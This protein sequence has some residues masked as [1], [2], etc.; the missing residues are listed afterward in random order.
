M[1]IRKTSHITHKDQNPRNSK[2]RPDK[3][4]LLRKRK[5]QPQPSS[6]GKSGGLLGWPFGHRL[7]FVV[8]LVLLG[9]LLWKQMN[10][11]TAN[12]Y[13]IN[14]T[15]FNTLVA[16]QKIKK[17]RI[18]NTTLYGE[19]TESLK[20]GETSD[21]REYRGIIVIIGEH[22][23]DFQDKLVAQGIEVTIDPER[24]WMNIFISSLPWILIFGI[25][26]F[27]IRQMQGGP[28]GVFSFGKSKAK[29]M[30]EN[31]Q[32][33]TFADVAGVE[34]AKVELQEIIEFLKDP[35]KFQRL[36][37]K[38]TKGRAADRTSRYWQNTTRPSSRR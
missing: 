31:T 33:I 24:T 8:L 37:A 20:L 28:K 2:Q 14:Y 32:Q 15:Q 27:I 30:A 21:N 16:A 6:S 26:L 1:N 4:D 10:S 22:D 29:L 9:V 12:Y 23:Q 5:Q 36:G 34:E 13:K 35:G 25:W 19:L 7:A 17:A 11:K 18:H 3:R 38:D